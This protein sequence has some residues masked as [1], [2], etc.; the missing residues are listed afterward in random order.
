MTPP[1][2]RYARQSFTFRRMEAWQVWTMSLV[3]LAILIALI[4]SYYL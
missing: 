2:D 3:V 1:D 4:G